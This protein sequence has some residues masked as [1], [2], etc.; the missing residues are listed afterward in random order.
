MP[1]Y[2]LLVN[3]IERE[4]EARPDT[5]LLWVLRDQLGLTGPKYGCGVG[6]CGA[7]VSLLDGEA[8]RVCVLPVGE[9][10]ERAVTTVEGLDD[11]PVQRA[12]IAGDVA[13]CGYCQAGQIMSTVALLRDRPQ[14]SDSDIDEALRDNVCRCGTYP[15]IRRA[16]HAA[17]E[18]AREEGR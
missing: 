18:L 17:A 16:V 8:A 6:A 15:R 4:V 2:R 5:P 3:G 9:L 1:V 7:C 14:P 12:W 13:Q 11:H 10:G